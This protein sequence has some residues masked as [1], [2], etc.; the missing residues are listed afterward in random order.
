M[1]QESFKEVLDGNKYTRK[2]AIEDLIYSA[3][4][5]EEEYKMM[6]LNHWKY[7]DLKKDEIFLI[8]NRIMSY[9][10]AAVKLYFCIELERYEIA[11]LINKH[12]PEITNEQ[13]I[14]IW[15]ARLDDYIEQAENGLD[16][17]LKN[18]D[19]E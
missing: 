2:H 9:P 14:N 6:I 11:A 15:N 3:N 16:S 1:Y 7:Q 17:Q 8:E 13:A 10:Q 19:Y 4:N 18:E 12:Y 5:G